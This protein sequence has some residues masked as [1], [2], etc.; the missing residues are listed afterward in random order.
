MKT[1]AIIGAAIILA[2]CASSKTSDYQIYAEQTAKIVQASAASEAACLLV[3]AEGVKS[4]DN[5]TKTA[6]TTQISQCKRATPKIEAPK[7]NW[8]GL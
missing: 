7:K 2:G 3:V 6:I 4:G 8:L 1:L 5:S